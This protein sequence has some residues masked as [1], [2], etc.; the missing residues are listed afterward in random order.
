[1]IMDEYLE[2]LQI[3]IKGMKKGLVYFRH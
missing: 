2:S 3:G 1:M